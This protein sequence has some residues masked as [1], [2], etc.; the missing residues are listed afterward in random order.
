MFTCVSDIGL[1]AKNAGA[2]K[3]KRCEGAHFAM[4]MALILY[5]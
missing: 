5:H 2:I 3:K 1:Y 4:Q